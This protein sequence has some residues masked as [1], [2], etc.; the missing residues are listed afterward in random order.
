NGVW[1]HRELR[2]AQRVT[3]Y[4]APRFPD[5]ICPPTADPADPR[6]GKPVAAWRWPGP[7]APTTPQKNDTSEDGMLNPKDVWA[8]K[9]Q[10]NG[11]AD[12]NDAYSYLRGTN[13]AVKSFGR[14]LDTLTAT[15]DTQSKALQALVDAQKS[16]TDGAKVAAAL[17]RMTAAFTAAEG[18]HLP[19][20]DAL[21]KD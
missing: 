3:G 15:I 8:Y 17:D 10:L 7:A 21:A 20:G 13:A 1:S 14:R 12:P 16:G 19:A 5:G 4:F 11:N 6:G 18:A 9:G 2:H